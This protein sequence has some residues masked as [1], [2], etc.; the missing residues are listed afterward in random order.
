MLESELSGQTMIR[1]LLEDAK[2]SVGFSAELRP[3]NFY[4]DE[5]YPWQPGRP[6][7]VMETDGWDVGGEVTVRFKTRVAGTAVHDPGAGAR[8][9]AT[10]ATSRAEEAVAAFVGAVRQPDRARPLARAD[11]SPAGSPRSPSRSAARRCRRMMADDWRVTVDLADGSGQELGAKLDE[12][13]IEEEPRERL[14]DAIAVSTDGSRLL[15]YADT[16]EAR[17]GGARRGAPRF[18]PR[19]RRS[20]RSRSTAGTRSPRSGSPATCPCRP[21][22][23]SSEAEREEVEAQDAADTA[24]VGY[25]EWEVRIDLPRA[26]G[27]DR[28]SPSC[29]RA[30]AS[31]RRGA[32]RTSL[33]GAATEDD[34]HALGRAPP[35]RGACRRDVRASSR[36]ARRPGRPRR[37]A[38]SGSS[39]S[40]TCRRQPAAARRAGSRPRSS[41]APRSRPP[42][43][44]SG[45]SRTRAPRARGRASRSPIPTDAS[46]A[47][48]PIPNAK[49]R[50]VA[51]RRTARARRRSPPARARCSRART[52]RP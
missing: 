44:S 30:R 46:I 26:L 37:A 22:P 39:S 16:R 35:R 6:P 29:S 8:A 4:G 47:C 14:G 23:R 19:R 38:R 41:S 45:A 20:R 40:R 17:G 33:V 51:R 18:S 13:E 52:G 50:A 9:R 48:S 3:Q 43:P 36:A 15:L 11:G 28:S 21:R 42:S 10:S 34:A 24:A 25:A 49:P 2:G 5:D 32:G 27:G 31:R 12:H 1:L 7:M